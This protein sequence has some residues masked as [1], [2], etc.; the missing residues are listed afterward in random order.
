MWYIHT[1]VYNSAI[2]RNE[3]LIHA[4]IGM[5]LGNI[6]LSERRKAGQ[7]SCCMIPFTENVQNGQVR[8]DRK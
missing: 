8:G 7:T 6:I 3:V 5:N 2:K 4:V 1:T